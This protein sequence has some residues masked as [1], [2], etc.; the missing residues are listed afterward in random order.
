VLSILNGR[1]VPRWAASLFPLYW[2]GRSVVAV[3]I[4]RMAMR[5]DGAGTVR[6]RLR[7]A[8]L[9]AMKARDSVAVVARFGRCWRRLIMPRPSMLGGH[10]NRVSGTQGSRGA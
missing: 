4:E 5:D 6:D 1:A 3:N 2:I 10:R 7:A 8:L 9:E